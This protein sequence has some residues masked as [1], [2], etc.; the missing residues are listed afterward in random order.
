MIWED[1]KCSSIVVT[2]ACPRAKRAENFSEIGEEACPLVKKSRTKICQGGP[3]KDRRGQAVDAKEASAE[4]MMAEATR[5][6]AS[7]KELLESSR[8]GRNRAAADARASAAEA[9]LRNAAADRKAAEAAVARLAHL[10]CAADK[11]TALEAAVAEAKAANDALR[12]EMRELKRG[13][14]ALEAVTE[15]AQARCAMQE[16]KRNQSSQQ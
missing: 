10:Q 9:A 11:V 1:K 5:R 7:A 13:C 14:A 3:E 12:E 6:F 4:K 16:A 2:F 15:A 8:A